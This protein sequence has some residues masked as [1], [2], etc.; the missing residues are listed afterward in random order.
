MTLKGLF[1]KYGLNPAWSEIEETD[2]FF[3]EELSAELCE[4][5]PLFAKVQRAAAR[6][7]AND[8]VLF[9]LKDGNWAI[10]HLTYAKLNADGF[11]MFKL[12]SD[13]HDVMCYMKEEN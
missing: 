9:L 5:H 1:K 8:D 2:S 13:L 12:F 3:L 7:H 4:S 11:P 6:C 10:V